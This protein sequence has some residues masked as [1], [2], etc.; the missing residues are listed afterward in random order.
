MELNDLHTPEEHAGVTLKV[1]L[2]VFVIVVIAALSYFVFA[3][4]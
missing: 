1:L 3:A 2:L 4:S